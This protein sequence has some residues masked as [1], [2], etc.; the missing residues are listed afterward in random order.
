[1]RFLLAL[2]V[3]LSG[4]SQVGAPASPEAPLIAKLNA[5]ELKLPS[6]ASLDYEVSEDGRKVTVQ[7]LDFGDV[8]RSYKSTYV[9]RERGWMFSSGMR[10]AGELPESFTN[11][12]NDPIV[13]SLIEAGVPDRPQ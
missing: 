11:A 9:L 5:L 1:M 8:P 7:V 3:V 2:F 10:D 6:T 13:L 12:P 4:C